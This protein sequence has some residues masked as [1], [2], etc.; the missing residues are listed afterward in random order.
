[1]Q[2]RPLRSVL[3]VCLGNICR[4][5]LA[6]GVFRSVLAAQGK[7]DNVL[8]DS[9][10]TT[11]YHTGELPDERSIAVASQYD[12]DISQQRCRQLTQADFTLFDVIAGMDRANVTAI[13]KR[14]PA[15]ATAE[16]GLFYE[17][18]LGESQ[19]I[20]DPYYGDSAEFERVYRMILAASNG[21]S[22]RF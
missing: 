18:A 20:P 14:G 8:I 4:S 21:F 7:G 10:G 12:I 22:K 6:E 17:L 19:Q 11:G 2:I 15:N 16:T 3:F 5:P 13:E 9:A 1:M